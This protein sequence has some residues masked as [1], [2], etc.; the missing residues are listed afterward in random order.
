IQELS[1]ENLGQAAIIGGYL[2]AIYAVMQFL[3]SPTLGN[4]SDRFGRRPVILFS[5]LAL[6]IDYIIMGFAPTLL[7]L[8]IGRLLAGIAGATHSTANAYMADISSPE[9][10][11]KNFGLV[12]AA[13]GLGFIAG[14]VIG[15]MVAEFGTRAPFFA[16]AALVGL[17]FLY[18]MFVLPETLSQDKRREFLWKR[19][20]PV[21]TIIQAFKIPGMLM[22]FAAFF[23]YQLSNMVYPSVWA[24]YT[25]ENFS[26]TAAQVGISLGAF[27]AMYALVQGGVIRLI[28]AKLRESH[29]AVLGL[30]VTVI[31]ML[32]MVFIDEGWMI[33]AV[34]PLTALG[35]VVVPA[36]SGVMS[37]S[38]SEDA[39]GELQGAL[40]S[41]MGITLIISPVMM[42]Q[43]FGYFT[44]TSSSVYL[45]GGVFGVSAVIAML[46]GIPLFFALRQTR[47]SK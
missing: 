17:N 28:L 40:S 15:G 38:V 26:W 33:Y 36:L 14:P 5:L 4:L 12:G 16:A 10:R 21:G 46:S 39:Q 32:I 13:F 8:F 23:L 37:R 9:D 25:K 24:Y 6:G 47:R 44:S 18:G 20:N 42:T 29:T 31:G 34:L 30:V 19:A 27:G 22:F 3:C 35:G 1:I 45:P 43:I 7:V 2:S 41:I 11:T